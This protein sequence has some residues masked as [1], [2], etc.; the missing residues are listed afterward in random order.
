MNILGLMSGSSLD[1][2]DMALCSFESLPSKPDFSHTVL[3]TKKVSFSDP[4]LE[5]LKVSTLLSA[6]ELLAFHSEFGAF[7]GESCASFIANSDHEVDYI[8][9]HGHTMLHFPEDGYTFQLG[10]GA[11]VAQISGVDTICD[12]RSNDIVMGGLGAPCAP[13]ADQYLLNDAGIFINLGGISNISFKNNGAI[14]AFDVSPC[15][16]LLNRLSQ[17]I[18]LEYDE[19]GKLA[20]NGQVDQELL[21]KLYLRNQ[22]DPTQPRALDNS[23]VEDQ[24]FQVMDDFPNVEDGLRTVVEFIVLELMKAIELNEQH[25]KSA[26]LIATGGGA[27][28]TFMM[29]EL[30]QKLSKIGVSIL[31][32]S[33]QLI[34]FKE[35]LLIAFMGY[36]RLHKVPNVLK[37]VTGA[38]IDTIGG[39]IYSK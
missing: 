36:L 9:S 24:F 4:I 6:K 17:R 31:P 25:F 14:K 27:M 15:N 3:E 2:L 1:G 38:R 19:D 30:G 37:S 13:L 39:C 7:I 33:E 35:A 8:A 32:S 22:Y 23:W 16:Q 26:R 21:E 11:H 18:G 12:F 10:H 20:S 5:Q 29:N 28:N 34:E